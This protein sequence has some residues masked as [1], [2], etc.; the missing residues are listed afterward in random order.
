[1][2]G[3]RFLSTQA[4]T[5]PEDY[6]TTQS[7][8][9]TF[10]FFKI[11]VVNKLLD[12]NKVVVFHHR[13]CAVVPCSMARKMRFVIVGPRVAYALAHLCQKTKVCFS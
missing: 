11:H 13:A 2:R 7:R 1:V 10:Y 5:V 3:E 12:F 8:V 9:N 4:T 6:I